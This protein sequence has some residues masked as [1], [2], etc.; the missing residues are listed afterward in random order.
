MICSWSLFRPW[1]SLS[2][3]SSLRNRKI[4][5]GK[6]S[7]RSLEVSDC[8]YS[9]SRKLISVVSKVAKRFWKLCW[10]GG[11]VWTKC[12]ADLL[13]HCPQS[14]IHEEGDLQKLVRVTYRSVIPFRQVTQGGASKIPIF[15]V[16]Y[17]SS[18]VT[19]P[20]SRDSLRII[21]LFWSFREEF[22]PQVVCAVLL[23]LRG[24][25]LPTL[26]HWLSF[27]RI[28]CPVIFGHLVN[29]MAYLI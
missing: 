7:L 5:V 12:S 3:L 16:V 25:T 6:S 24:I 29:R 22:W 14:Y 9:K 17:K 20:R 4:F 18:S 27:K 15:L 26:V 1:L 2:C 13:Q 28:M 19:F 8:P 10:L 23:I 21:Y 11:C